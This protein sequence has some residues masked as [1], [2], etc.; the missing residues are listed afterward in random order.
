MT[1]KQFLA[2]FAA[3]VLYR[4]QMATGGRCGGFGLYNILWRVYTAEY[5]IKRGGLDWAAAFVR[6]FVRAFVTK[7]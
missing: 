6:A 4:L 1:K 3:E 2:G 7:S 5:T